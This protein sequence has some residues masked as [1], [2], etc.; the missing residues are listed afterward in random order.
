MLFSYIQGRFANNKSLIRR[1]A[2]IKV[3]IWVII[4]QFSFVVKCFLRN[5]RNGYFRIEGRK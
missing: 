1:L 5:L 3:Q 4:H 2:E